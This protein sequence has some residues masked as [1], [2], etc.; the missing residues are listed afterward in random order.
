MGSRSTNWR[1][2]LDAETVVKPDSRGDQVSGSDTPKLANSLGFRCA[3]DLCLAKHM[4]GKVV[5]QAASEAAAKPACKEAA[6]III[7]DA[8]ASDPCHLP[9]VAVIT[10]RQLAN[11]GSAAV[12]FSDQPD[13]TRAQV[14]YAVEAHYRPWHVQR[15]F[16]R[17][18]R[19]LGPYEKK[20]GKAPDRPEPG[21]KG[22]AGAK[23]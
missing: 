17:E 11:T 8:T 16:S 7:D 6:V 2:A 15:Q 19:G 4:S 5:A 18:A 14:R 23:G 13:D 21:V 1:R 20:Q 3:N 10:K 22:E 12:F 9:S